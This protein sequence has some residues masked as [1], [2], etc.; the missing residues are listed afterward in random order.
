MSFHLDHIG[1]AVEDLQAALQVYQA[2][3]L[4]VL[5]QESVPTESVNVAFLDTGECHLELLEASSED[6]PIA[7]FIRKRGAGIHHICLKV[8]QLENVMAQ[9]KAAGIKLIDEQPRPG[10]NGKRVAFI[11]PKALGGVLL[12]L[13]EDPAE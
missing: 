13:S 7:G 6:S 10:A 4:E 5:K 9:L 8:T 11:H 12:E 2:L 1:V 3:G